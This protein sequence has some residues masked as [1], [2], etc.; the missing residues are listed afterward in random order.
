M[1]QVAIVGFPAAVAPFEVGCQLGAVAVA[2]IETQEPGKGV[3]L[4]QCAERCAGLG[5]G[6]QNRHQLA[7]LLAHDHQA[8]ALS[9]FLLY[10]ALTQLGEALD[11]GVGGEEVCLRAGKQK[12]LHITRSA[13]QGKIQLSVGFHPFGN[14]PAPGFLRHLR[15][16]LDHVAAGAAQRRG[17][18]QPHVELEN[19]RLQGQHAIKL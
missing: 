18:E 19:V 12:T 10:I 6:L 8:T 11:E 4:W 1:A 17:L 7:K 3:Q 15:Q 5:P 2:L 13:L 16:G 14:D 9:Q